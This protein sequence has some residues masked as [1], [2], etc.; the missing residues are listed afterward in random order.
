MNQMF[1]VRYRD[2]NNDLTK[3]EVEGA[4]TIDALTNFKAQYEHTL[5]YAVIPHEDTKPAP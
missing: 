4:D 3:V 5:V 1:L 2:I